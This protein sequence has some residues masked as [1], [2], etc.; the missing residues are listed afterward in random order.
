MNKQYSTTLAIDYGTKRIGLAISHASL[1]VP[2]EVI[3]Y[4]T[5]DEVI[6]R[7]RQICQEHQIAQLLLG[8]SEQQ[9]AEQTK[10]F[11]E[12]LSSEIDLPIEYVDETL[13]S[14]EVRQKMKERGKKIIG[15]IDH[16]AASIFL[17]EWLE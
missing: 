1:A 17:E 14:F 10:K 5:Q 15:P 3:E 7:I 12:L 16:Y 8:I 4:Q 9:M 2:L 11:G 6:A 13:S